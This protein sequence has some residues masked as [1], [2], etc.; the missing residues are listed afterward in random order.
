MKYCLQAYCQQS[1]VNTSIFKIL[2]FNSL[3]LFNETVP[4]QNIRIVCITLFCCCG[5]DFQSELY[6][7]AA[8]VLETDFGTSF[9]NSPSATVV[10]YIRDRVDAFSVQDKTRIEFEYRHCRVEAFYVILY[11]CQ[12]VKIPHLWAHNVICWAR[13]SAIF[14]TFEQRSCMMK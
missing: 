6:I 3:N 4:K 13:R 9:L 1:R 2:F 14:T 10:F 8:T 11:K 5:N 7:S 12:I